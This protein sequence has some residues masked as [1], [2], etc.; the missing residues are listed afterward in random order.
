MGPAEA[1]EYLAG[2]RK[3]L[4]A[5]DGS[6]VE[7][8]LVPP[9]VT[10]P[11]VMDALGGCSCVG[12]GAQN[13]SDR[14]NG[15]YTGEVS[16]AMLAELGVRYVVLGHSERRRYYGE[17]DSFINGKIKKALAA[18]LTPIHCIGETLEQRDGGQLESVLRTQVTEGLAGLAPEQAASVVIAYEP[19]WAI[20]TGRTATARQA[21]EAHAFVR[22]VLADSFGRETAE[23]IRIQ[24]GGSMKPD[25]AP[26]LMAQ[27]DI[28]G[29]LIG[30][31]GLKPD[32][33]AAIIRA[34]C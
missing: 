7:K 4:A 33:F 23:K 30:G 15:A 27:P 10:I 8:V 19:V 14:D 34:A 3:E 26:E 2:F 1:R 5:F 22:S 21:Q 6:H 9:F 20:G 31:A 16:T 24:Y 29:G 17:T 28:D 13:C 32:S 11:A 12:V 25:N 18:G